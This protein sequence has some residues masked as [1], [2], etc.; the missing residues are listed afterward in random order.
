MGRYLVSNLEWE[1]LERQ[2]PACY[3]VLCVFGFG[4]P[5]KW[6]LICYQGE[7]VNCPFNGK[8]FSRYS[9]VLS[10]GGGQFSAYID[11]GVF[12]SIEFL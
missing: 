8:G 10:F 12:F 11:D 9:H 1:A 5:L 2:K 3:F 4:H 7:M 6:S